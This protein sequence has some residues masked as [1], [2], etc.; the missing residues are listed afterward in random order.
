MIDRLADSH[1][2]GASAELPLFA[3]DEPALCKSS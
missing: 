3:S 1:A 2:L